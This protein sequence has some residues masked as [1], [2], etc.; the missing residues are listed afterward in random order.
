MNIIRLKRKVP[1]NLYDEVLHDQ[2]YYTIFGKYKIHIYEIQKKN[3]FSM[4]YI[5][6]E[7]YQGKFKDEKNLI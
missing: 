1:E 6:M 7:D 5:Y 3:F 2:N 4:L